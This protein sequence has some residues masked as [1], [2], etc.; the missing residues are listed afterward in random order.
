MKALIIK[1][2][3]S[4]ALVTSVAVAPAGAAL[5]DRGSFDD[6]F[7]G[8]MNLIYD[9]DL[10]ITW[11]GDA[12]FAQTSGFDADGR[13]TWTVA[14]NSWAPSLTVGGFTDW[15]LPT[16]TQP[17]ASCS[18]QRTSGGSVLQGLRFDCTGSEMGHLFYDE[19]GG[20]ASSSILTSG[21]TD[22]LALFNNIQANVYW[23]GTEVAPNTNNAWIFLFDSGD[24]EF[25]VKGDSW[26][27]WAVR[28]G[29]VSAPPAVPEPSTMLLLGSGLVGL[30]GWGRVRR[31]L[32]IR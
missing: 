27:G 22:L 6:G 16:T 18:R 31:G 2:A 14:N 15:R 32:M 30:I 4:L 21:D 28:S 5:I 8:L 17:D 25:D 13:M 24:Q 9:D 10:N 26:F 1:A 12:N 19:L 23:S 20:T 7:G 29:D 3:V 11:L